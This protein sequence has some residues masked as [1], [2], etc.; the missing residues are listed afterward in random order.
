MDDT[1][2]RDTNAQRLT[3]VATFASENAALAAARAIRQ[4]FSPE[5]TVDPA[6]NA[7]PPSGREGRFVLRLV[8]LIAAWSVAGTAIGALF[9]TALSYTVGPHGTEGLIIQVVSWAIFAHLMIGL[10]AG[11][12]LLADRSQREFAPG[13]RVLLRVRVERRNIDRVTAALLRA[14]ASAVNEE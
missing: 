10:W 1:P 5:T 13:D 6:T 14:G 2:R 11:Y 4:A 7:S 9:G 8:L 12:V 3:L